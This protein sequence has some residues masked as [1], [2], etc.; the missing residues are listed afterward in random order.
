M[1]TAHRDIQAELAAMQSAPTA[2]H[3]VIRYADGRVRRFAAPSLRQ[4]QAGADRW[5]RKIGKALIDH[6]TGHVVTVAS[7]TVEAV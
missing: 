7:A 3:Y 4:A 1:Q 2:A 5:S 6:D